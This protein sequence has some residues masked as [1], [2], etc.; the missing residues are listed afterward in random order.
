MFQ[1]N[2]NK[3]VKMKEK[4]KEKTKEEVVENLKFAETEEGRT[5]LVDEFLK[6]AEKPAEKKANKK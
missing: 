2:Q 1:K 3:E 4:V 5:G 6:S